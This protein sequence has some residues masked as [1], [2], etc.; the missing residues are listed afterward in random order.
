MRFLVLNLGNLWSK[1]FPSKAKFWHLPSYRF[2]HIEKR[3]TTFFLSLRRRKKTFFRHKYTGHFLWTKNSISW[4]ILL[5][6][7]KFHSN[8]LIF[9]L[10][11]TPISLPLI[12]PIAFKSTNLFPIFLQMF[13]KSRSKKNHLNTSTS[14]L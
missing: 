5:E 1:K 10:F 8:D 13:R 2:I 11:G 12:E 7:Y 14:N 9:R 3:K 4:I 6:V